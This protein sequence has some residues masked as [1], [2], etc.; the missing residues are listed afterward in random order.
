VK[1]VSIASPTK[2]DVFIDMHFVTELIECCVLNAFY[3]C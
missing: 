2:Y 3:N 1:F